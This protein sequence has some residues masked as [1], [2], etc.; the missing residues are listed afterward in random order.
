MTFIL[1]G[2]DTSGRDLL[3]HKRS[4]FYPHYMGGGKAGYRTRR[5]NRRANY[6]SSDGY[7]VVGIFI[8]AF[9]RIEVMSSM[10]RP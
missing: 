10:R 8:F 9:K 1:G 2:S 4:Y 5:M 3:L 7:I 6:C